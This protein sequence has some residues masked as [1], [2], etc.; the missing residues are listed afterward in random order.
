[1]S[2]LCVFSPPWTDR[3]TKDQPEVSAGSVESI[4]EG[5]RGD[6]WLP[7][8]GKVLCIPF[9]SP[10]WLPGG[11]SAAGAKSAGMSAQRGDCINMCLWNLV[12]MKL[13]FIFFTRG[14]ILNMFLYTDYLATVSNVVL[15]CHLWRICK[16]NWRNRRA[17]WGSLE[18]WPTS[19][20]GSVTRQS[21]IH[22][23][24]PWRMS[25]QGEFY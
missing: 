1:M 15:F 23:T 25:M 19:C 18:P 24:T 4:Q 11:C 5:F 10:H 12:V 16:R 6:Q 14:I 2:E 21:Q 13:I 17:V 3:A 8:G 22:S 20:W 9:P 7:D